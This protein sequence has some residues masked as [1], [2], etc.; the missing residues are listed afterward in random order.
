MSEDGATIGRDERSPTDHRRSTAPGST[1]LLETIVR[2]E[3]RTVAR[4]RT[5]FVLGAAF[6]AVVLGIAWVGESVR[7]GYVP[8]LVDLL[9]P[10]ELLVPIVAVAFGYRAIIGDEQR[11]ELDVLETYPV[12][13]REIVLGVY[14]GRAIGLL[15]VVVVPLVL[16]GLVVSVTESDALRTYASHAGADSPILFARFVVLTALF[17][18]TVLA[19]AIAV[20]AI[21][22]GTRSALALAIVALVVLLVGLDL[23]LAY[24][25][26]AGV[27]GDA[28]LVHSLAISP[29]SAY[30]G[31]VFE[32]AVVVAAGTGPA[33][34]APV[35]SLLSFV[36]WTVASLAVAT[37]AV[38]R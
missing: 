30:R 27:I 32:S 6:A 25:F 4:T 29:L 24:G 1:R 20:S 3:L 33:V 7:A 14:V 8:T 22:G 13:S 19:V 37:W 34:A 38:N 36:L 11:G 31:L 5:F 15:A 28:G 12:S 26:S 16:V 35:S 21:V 9:T 18:L 2:R 10:L 17:A 23:A